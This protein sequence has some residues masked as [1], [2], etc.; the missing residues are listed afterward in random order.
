MRRLKFWTTKMA[1]LGGKGKGPTESSNGRQ[2][3]L[4]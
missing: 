1:F 4:G 2:K 3:L